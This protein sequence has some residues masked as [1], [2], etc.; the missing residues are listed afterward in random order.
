MH[1]VFDRIASIVLII[2][3]Y[4]AASFAG[5]P[6]NIDDPEPVDFLHW[7]FYVASSYVLGELDDN[8]TLPHFEVNYGAVHNVQLHLLIGPGYAKAGGVTV[9]KNSM[10]GIITQGRR[11]VLIILVVIKF[12]F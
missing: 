3:I 2:M 8:A 11:I 4:T 1:N 7:E 10:N 6:I 5:P 12:V 9:L